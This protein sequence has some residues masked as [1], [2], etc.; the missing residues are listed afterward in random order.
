MT[1][2]YEPLGAAVLLGTLGFLASAPCAWSAERPNLTSSCRPIGPRDSGWMSLEV[3]GKPVLDRFGQPRLSRVHQLRGRREV[4]PRL[5]DHLS[6]RSSELG[7][8]LPAATSLDGGASWTLHDA[9][10]FDIGQ[11]GWRRPCV[12]R[13]PAN[14]DRIWYSASLF[15]DAP[16]PQGGMWRSDDKRPDLDREP[17]R[18][19]AGEQRDGLVHPPAPVGGHEPFRL[20]IPRLVAVESKRKSPPSRASAQRRAL[21]RSTGKERS[22]EEFHESHG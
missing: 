9:P 13:S 21:D 20:E 14:T 16:P 22:E 1:S 3:P 5:G 2:R 18:R 7:G 6:R 8:R 4:Q 10:Q 17:V 15:L 19:P 11:P 12:T